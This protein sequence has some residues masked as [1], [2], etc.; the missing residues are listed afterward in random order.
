[1]ADV[2]L[3]VK[4]FELAAKLSS[5]CVDYNH[6]IE[7]SDENTDPSDFSQN[8]RL[9]IVDMDEQVFSS[10]GLIAA[11]KRKG[12]KIVGTMTKINNKDRSKLL[13]AGCDIILTKASLIK[14]VPK[15]SIICDLILFSSLTS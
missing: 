11:L 12:I 9:A 8:V 6:Q 3:F 10:V 7:F 5:V 2:I 1:M 14:N 13:A 15:L 4:D